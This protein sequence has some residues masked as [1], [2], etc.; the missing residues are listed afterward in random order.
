MRRRCFLPGWLGAAVLVAV[1]AP[2]ARAAGPV[3][4]VVT[5]IPPLAMIAS[6]LGGDR[7]LARSI[8]PPGADP[9]T[10]EPKPSD[11]RAIAEADVVVVL[12][13]PID[14]WIGK[15]VS[16]SPR[17]VVVRLDEGE[18]HDATHDHH[19]DHHEDPHVWLDP[20]WVRD[21]AL[22]PLQRA[23]A[24]ADPAGAAHYGA[25]ARAMS[26]AMTDLDDDIRTALVAATTRSFLAWHPA[27]H[28]FA[29][30]F[31]LHPVGSVGE[32]SGREPSMR[33]MIDAIRAARASGVRAVLIEPQV[34]ARQARVL[35]DELGVAIHTVDPLGDP[36]SLERSTYRLLM[37][38]NANVFA[39]ALGVVQDE[40]EDAA[41][42]VSAA[43]AT[44]R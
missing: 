41:A 43:P 37:L 14:S 44:C 19:G 13:S 20:L 9:H 6:E 39:R 34:D 35:A 33:A 28:R 2:D 18:N 12:G 4:R 32:I 31:G 17:A 15:A 16:P 36:S 42:G 21:A 22:R 11:A 8:L 27:W 23:L 1:A 7:V 10:F 5:S 38:Y 40:D 25:A 24:E 26:E 3:L 29:E 30:R